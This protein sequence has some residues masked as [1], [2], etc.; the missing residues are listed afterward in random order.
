MCLRD[1]QEIAGFLP[2]VFPRTERNLLW[3]PGKKRFTWNLTNVALETSSRGQETSL[4]LHLPRVSVLARFQ[5]RFQLLACRSFCEVN[6]LQTKWSHRKLRSMPA[7]HRTGYIYMKVILNAEFFFRIWLKRS[8][9]RHCILGFCWT[10]Y[11]C[12]SELERIYCWT[13]FA[14]KRR[15]FVSG[16]VL[17]NVV[18]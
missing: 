10:V 4:F 17:Q 5:R 9:Q 13:A 14:G 3:S 15:T 7:C 2:A 18:V 8:G 16:F 6:W 11:H 1:F 12:L